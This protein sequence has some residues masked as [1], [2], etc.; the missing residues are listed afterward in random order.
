[1]A[2]EEARPRVYCE[3]GRR[4]HDEAGMWDWSQSREPCPP[5]RATLMDLGIWL[6]PTPDT[7]DRWLP[8]EAAG[9]R[10]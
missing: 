7:P 1:M 10:A 3:H 5:C 6:E 8:F 4:V 2:P 9:R